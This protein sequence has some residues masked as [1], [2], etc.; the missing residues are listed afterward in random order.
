MV[1]S[2]C[3]K[4]GASKK[5]SLHKCNQCSFQPEQDEYK[6]KSLILS[7]DYEINEIPRGKSKQEL[8]HISSDIQSG[9]AYAFDDKEI[10][11][12]ISFA[13]Q[14]GAIS[15][16]KLLIDGIKWLFP[17]LLLLAVLYFLV[18]FT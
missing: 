8:E 17:P 5:D 13:H 11:S 16:K 4:C 10:A 3:I 9:K 6:A 14:V 7:L 1:Y 2:I 12:I 15:G 18:Y